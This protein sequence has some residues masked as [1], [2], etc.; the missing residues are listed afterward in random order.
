[1]HHRHC[2]RTTATSECA[3]AEASIANAVKANAFT[4]TTVQEVTLYDLL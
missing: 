4:T 3:D 1:M 2:P